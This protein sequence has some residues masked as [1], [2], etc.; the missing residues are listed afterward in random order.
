MDSSLSLSSLISV[1][2]NLTLEQALKIMAEE[3][4]NQVPVVSAPGLIVGVA[5]I[6][7]I[8]AKIG[9]GEISCKDQIETA[10]SSNFKKVSLDTNLRTLSRV[11][12]TNHVALVIH[13]QKLCETLLHS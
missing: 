12:D 5:T 8:R 6:A 13:Q 1:Q 9:K 7:T 3:A 2:P 10:V 4:L 11:L